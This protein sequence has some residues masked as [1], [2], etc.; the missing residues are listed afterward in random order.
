MK[1]PTKKIAPSPS[2]AAFRDKMLNIMR[3]DFAN[4]PA[5]EILAIY[6]YTMGQL[7]A[8]QD[9]RRFTSAMVMQLVSDNIEAGNQDAIREV[10]SAGGT[11]S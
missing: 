2:H 8:M 1:V 4:T 11:Q 10:A 3:T 5:E 9:Q 7:I 6:A